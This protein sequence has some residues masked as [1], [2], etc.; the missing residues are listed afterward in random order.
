[1]LAIPYTEVTQAALI[2]VAYPEG[3]N[4]TPATREPLQSKL[5][6]NGW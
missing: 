5:H 1:M 2:P 6:W 4:F 3:L